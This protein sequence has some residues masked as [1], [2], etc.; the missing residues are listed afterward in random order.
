MKIIISLPMLDI[1]FFETLRNPLGSYS[2]NLLP[3]I[4]ENWALN[5]ISTNFIFS[6]R[7]FL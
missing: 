6:V 1:L 5:Y 7:T 2:F 3:E 4:E